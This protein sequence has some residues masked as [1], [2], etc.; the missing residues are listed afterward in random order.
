MIIAIIGS[1]L[2]KPHPKVI[3]FLTDILVKEDPDGF[4]SGG[5]DGT[6]KISENIFKSLY[7]ERPTYIYLPV[8]YQWN[9]PKGFKWR[10]IKIA[11][12]G[13]KFFR[14]A[15]VNSKTYGSGWTCD[16]AERLGKPVERY[17]VDVVFNIVRQS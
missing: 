12:K 7:P 4:T 13:D 14:L 9:H 3:K 17:I 2:V 5:A 8:V 1:T 10:N 16:Q 15:H 11:K 6:D